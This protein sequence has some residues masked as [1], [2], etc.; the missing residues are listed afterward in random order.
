ME[1]T[2]PPR[3][4][5][6][7]AFDGAPADGPADA[8]S[9]PNRGPVP[10]ADYASWLQLEYPRL[11]ERF[12]GND[13]QI[14]S[15][16]TNRWLAEYSWLDR[17]ANIHRRWHYVLRIVAIVGGVSLPALA[18]FARDD[19]NASVALA[20]ISVAV[21][22]AVALDGLFRPGERWRHFRRAAEELKTEGWRYLTGA[23]PYGHGR[24]RAASFSLF[25]L[26]VE[27]LLGSE[28]DEYVSRVIAPGESDATA[29]TPA[30]SGP[31]TGRP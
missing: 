23:L 8:G 28:V 27:K 14:R 1:P 16:L 21:A 15:Y 20:L 5:P 11:I 29:P 10:D 3:P 22:A 4:A 13:E 2:P 9:R 7:G 12:A 30:S 31:D 17:Q 19:P 26:R 24:S 25:A 6:A 18:S